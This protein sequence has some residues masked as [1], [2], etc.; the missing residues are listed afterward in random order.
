MFNLLLIAL[1]GAFGAVSRYLVSISM[2]SWLGRGFPYGTL[3]VNVLGSFIIGFLSVLLLDRLSHS[4]ELRALLMVGFLGA[5]T[6]FSSFSLETLSLYEQGA[7]GLATLNI[8]ANV[9]L[10]LLAVTA[11]VMLARQLS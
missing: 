7:Y 6:T 2:Q 9:V 4:S 3:L 1:G 8:L 11:A 5:F 10:C